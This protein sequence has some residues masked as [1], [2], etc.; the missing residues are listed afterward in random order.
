MLPRCKSWAGC[1][2]KHKIEKAQVKVKA[3]SR[4]T[5]AQ[6]QGDQVTTPSR[7]HGRPRSCKLIRTQ[8]VQAL[9]GLDLHTKPTSLPRVDATIT[10]DALQVLD[11]DIN[12]MDP[13]MNLGIP[14]P[15]MG[16]QEEV[17]RLQAQV[18]RLGT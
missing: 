15:R 12:I 7:P 14:A 3:V 4:V 1:T 6:N 17:M 9:D 13:P 2:T 5:R 10:R 16:N 11:I 8:V 18:Q